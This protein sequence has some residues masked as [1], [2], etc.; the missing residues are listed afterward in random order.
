MRLVRPYDFAMPLV[1]QSWL[2]NA[3]EHGP[4]ARPK[5]PNIGRMNTGCGVGM[6]AFG[7]PICAHAMKPPLMTIS[8]FA[9]NIEGFHNTRSASLPTSIEPMMCAMPWASAGL[10]VYFE[11]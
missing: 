7:A 3:I 10:I 2:T 9:P 4:V 8:G 11:R 6:L 1:L 5:L